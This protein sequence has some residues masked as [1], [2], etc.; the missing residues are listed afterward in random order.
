VRGEVVV[1]LTTERTERAA[2]GSTL[3][4]EGHGPVTITASRPHLGRWIVA[5]E[6]VADR[7]AAEA[8]HGARLLA[9]P[10]T[11][12]GELFAH[13]L[14]G[15]PVVDTAGGAC[16]T[17]EAVQANPAAD[18]LVLDTGALV[19]ATFLVE[20]RA[21][22]VVVIDPPPGLLDLNPRQ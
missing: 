19:P 4:A 20:R 10:I 8:L 3:H 11:D 15:S 13:D 1:E 9:E 18:L 21:D 6:G 17:V 16:G 5:L 7:A 22:G 14:I 2:V 12:P